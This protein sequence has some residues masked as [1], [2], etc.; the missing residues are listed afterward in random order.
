MPIMTAGMVVEKSTSTDQGEE[1][2]QG[3]TDVVGGA[4]P[5]FR[6]ERKLWLPTDYRL[7]WYLYEVDVPVP[8]II[9]A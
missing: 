6:N 7:L 8:V 3:H 1:T 2:W 9:K 5:S 4:E